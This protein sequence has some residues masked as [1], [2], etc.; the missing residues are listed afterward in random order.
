MKEYVTTYPWML[1]PAMKLGKTVYMLD[2]ETR[3]VVCVN[4]MPVG[5]F[6]EIEGLGDDQNRYEFWYEEEVKQDGTV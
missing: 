3:L 2:R 4:D 5:Q 1:R 6:M